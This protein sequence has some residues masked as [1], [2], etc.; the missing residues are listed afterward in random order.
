MICLQLVHESRQPTRGCSTPPPNWRMVGFGY[1]DGFSMVSVLV[2]MVT[3]WTGHTISHELRLL[4]SHDLTK[5]L[6]C[7]V[8]QSREN[9]ELVLKLVLV[10]TY[11]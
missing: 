11:G 4:S 5:L 7:V 9:I 2:C 6:H 3:H 1:R 8:S 10:L